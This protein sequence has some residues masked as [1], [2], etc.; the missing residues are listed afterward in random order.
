MDPLA[1]VRIT[2]LLLGQ[3]CDVNS[4]RRTIVPPTSGLGRGVPFRTSSFSVSRI[5]A[6]LISGIEDNRNRTDRSIILGR[7]LTALT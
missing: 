4:S 2:Y 5:G 6:A 1:S 3:T 7:L